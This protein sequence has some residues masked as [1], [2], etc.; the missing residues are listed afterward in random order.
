MITPTAL[1]SMCLRMIRQGEAPIAT[2][3]ETY[4]FSRSD[5]TSA[6]TS[7]AIPVQLTIPRTMASGKEGRGTTALT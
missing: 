7:R 2:A 5:S 4:S 6:R 1:G 3:A